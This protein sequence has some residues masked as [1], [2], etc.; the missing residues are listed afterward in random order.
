MP[1]NSF[2]ETRYIFAASNNT[3]RKVTLDPG[4]LF[5]SKPLDVVKFLPGNKAYL[6]SIQQH[7]AKSYTGSRL[8]FSPSRWMLWNSFPETRHIFAA[9][10][11]T[12]RKDTLDSGYLFPQAVGCC[13]IPSRKQG[14][15]S[16]CL[17]YFKKYICDWYSMVE[18]EDVFRTCFQIYRWHTFIFQNIK[19]IN[20]GVYIFKNDSTYRS[21]CTNNCL[22]SQKNNVLESLARFSISKH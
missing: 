8:S 7:G 6:R 19:E 13:E 15:S 14:M 1:W 16:Q 18:D 11:N 3:E 21:T 12:E 17:K 2:P 10:N 5:C 4:Y 9:S 22:L 20:D